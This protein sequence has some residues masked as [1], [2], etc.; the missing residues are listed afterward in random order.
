MNHGYGRFFLNWVDGGVGKCHPESL[1]E[2]VEL[3]G[4]TWRCRAT[5][6]Q[7]DLVYFHSLFSV[8]PFIRPLICHVSACACRASVY[9]D[10]GLYI[11]K[12]LRSRLLGVFEMMGR[13][14]GMRWSS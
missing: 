2:A 9:S 14:I 12:V 6:S 4:L 1:E 5:H 10:C 7:S 8:E 13:V 11:V 3:L